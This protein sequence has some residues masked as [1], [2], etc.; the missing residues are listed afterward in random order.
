MMDKFLLKS[1]R[2]DSRSAWEDPDLIPRPWYGNEVRNSNF[3]H[4]ISATHE[5]LVINLCLFVPSSPSSPHSQAF[6]RNLMN[7][8]TSPGLTSPPD[9]PPSVVLNS[10]GSPPHTFP[11]LAKRKSFISNEEIYES[12][13]S[14]A[15][16]GE[17]WWEVAE[18][19]DPD[20]LLNG[21]VSSLIPRLLV[22]FCLPSYLCP[23]VW[24]PS[25]PPIVPY[26]F[27]RPSIFPF[28]CPYMYCVC[29]CACVCVCVCVCSMHAGR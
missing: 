19:I 23:S 13:P 2:L 1:F 6:S 20:G 27:V 8:T 12:N 21:L 28:V 9:P 14:L 24:L 10:P 15:D 16:G 4:I 25:Y 7:G 26:M 29:V 5:S 11:T 18:R 17:D 22:I 3:A